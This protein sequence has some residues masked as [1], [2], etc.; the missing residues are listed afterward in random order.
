GVGPA[1]GPAAE[2]IRLRLRLLPGGA[3]G[4]VG[5]AVELHLEGSAGDAGGRR[6]RRRGHRAGPLELLSARS[7]L[8]GAYRR[9]SSVDRRDAGRAAWPQLPEDPGEPPGALSQLPRY[10]E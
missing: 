5:A 6:V 4:G 10:V 8:Q 1:S 7:E 2:P 9:G 3:A